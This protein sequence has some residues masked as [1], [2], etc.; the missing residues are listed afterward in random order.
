MSFDKKEK[1]SFS[2]APKP[3][4]DRRAKRNIV[5]IIKLLEKDIVLA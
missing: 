3:N 4:S 1:F 5:E 2:Y